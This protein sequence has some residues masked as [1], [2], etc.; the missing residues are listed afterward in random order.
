MKGIVVSGLYF[1]WSSFVK[2][3]AKHKLLSRQNFPRQYKPVISPLSPWFLGGERVLVSGHF[4]KEVYSE[5]LSW[6]GLKLQWLGLMENDHK[7]LKIELFMSNLLYVLFY[8]GDSVSQVQYYSYPR[9]WFAFGG[10]NREFVLDTT[11][12]INVLHC[13]LPYLK[14][15]TSIFDSGNG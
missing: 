11:P 6:P 13:W 10:Y 14:K 3:S 15:G 7:G 9:T 1:R 8:I 5:S 4:G 2:V 12:A